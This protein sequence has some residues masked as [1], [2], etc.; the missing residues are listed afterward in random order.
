MDFLLDP[1]N[2]FA[3]DK[4]ARPSTLRLS[5]PKL[6]AHPAKPLAALPRPNKLQTNNDMFGAKLSEVCDLMSEH[7]RYLRE[8][9]YCVAQF[10]R[11]SQTIITY[12]GNQQLSIKLSF[13][14][15]GALK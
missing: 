2:H 15:Y 9:H 5:R 4:R 13:F 1:A 11:Y 14:M 12:G 10:Y 6:A 8:T 3:K 7:Y